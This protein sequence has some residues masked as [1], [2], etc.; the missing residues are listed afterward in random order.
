MLC[1]TLQVPFLFYLNLC[2]LQS[3]FSLIS[4]PQSLVTTSLL[5]TFMISVF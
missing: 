4:L 2:T 3:K 5:S 1:K